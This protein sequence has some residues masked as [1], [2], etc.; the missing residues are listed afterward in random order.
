MSDLPASI[1]IEPSDIVLRRSATWEGM[2]AEIV[3]VT[4]S[5]PVELHFAAPVHLLIAYERGLR[6]QGEAR[7]PGAATSA[8]KNL[9]RKLTFVP[10]GREFREWQ[11]PN[12]A[13][14]FM[15]LYIEP[16]EQV[17]LPGGGKAS[18][19]LAPRLLFEDR[20]LWETISKL[21]G[22]IESGVTN[23]RYLEA[24]GAVLAH[25]LSQIMCGETSAEQP[26]RGGLAA[27]QVR[28]VT[29]YIEQHLSEDIS[30]KT[31]AGLVRLSQHHFCR[32]FKQSLGRSPC[33]YHGMRRMEQAKRLLANPNLT[34]SD[35]AL[36]AGFNETSTFTSAFRRATG[37][38]PT[39]FR[40]G[41]SWSC[42][43][44]M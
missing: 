29:D 6:Q 35:I 16:S 15:C 33:R 9:R 42:S 37:V 19:L 22:L 14:Q 39:M 17:G 21:K 5:R 34:V 43:P 11:A 7:V 41:L 12:S 27:W 32:A 38:P 18:R 31:L 10:A 20:V 24:V 3:Q 13:T 28:L 4:R 44:N 23:W 26:A 2:S 1:R 8:L 36:Q 25:E 30:L 40:R